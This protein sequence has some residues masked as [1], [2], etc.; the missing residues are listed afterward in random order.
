M[1]IKEL[2]ELIASLEEK[3]LV[4][5]ETDIVIYDSNYN[6]YC[7]INEVETIPED[8]KSIIED[9]IRFVI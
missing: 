6:E 8:D 5:D 3:K 1:N 4:T 2:K 7:I 9:G